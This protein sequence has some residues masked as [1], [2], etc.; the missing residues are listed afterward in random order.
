MPQKQVTKE[1]LRDELHYLELRN[2]GKIAEANAFRKAYLKMEPWMA[3]VFK[4]KM[5]L[6]FLLNLGW[7]ME[8]VEAEFGPDWLRK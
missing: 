2:A 5:G 8:D 7:N 4:D 1:E 3:K 6:E